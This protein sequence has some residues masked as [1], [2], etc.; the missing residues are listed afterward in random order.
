[1][2]VTVVSIHTVNKVT[3]LAVHPLSFQ[4]FGGV[5]FF[6]DQCFDLHKPITISATINKVSI[7]F[8]MVYAKSDGITVSNKNDSEK[9]F[10]WIKKIF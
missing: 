10:L 2:R 5:N 1:M 6:Y 8:P 7:F 3:G 9:G 4:V